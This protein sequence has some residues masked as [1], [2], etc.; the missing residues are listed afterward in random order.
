MEG[1]AAARPDP[2]PTPRQRDARPPSM[3][4][5]AAAR[6]DTED[7]WADFDAAVALQW[8]AGQLPGLTRIDRSFQLGMMSLQWRAGQLPG[9][10]KCEWLSRTDKPAL[11]WRAGQLPGLTSLKTA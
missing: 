8:R 7:A 5:R 4:G 2:A 9:L 10:T 3:E 11:Q 6:P 1:R